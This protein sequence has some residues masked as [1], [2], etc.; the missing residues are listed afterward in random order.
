MNEENITPEAVPAEAEGENGAVGNEAPT[1]A[2]VLSET[3]GKDFKDDETAL[4]SVK[5][6]FSYVGKQRDQVKTEVK[7]E[8][9]IDEVVANVAKQNKELSSELFY[10]KNKEFDSPEVRDMIGSMGNDPK[11]VVQSDAFKKIFDKVKGFEKAQEGANVLKSN[12]N[13]RLDTTS[14]AT[15]TAMKSGSD[16][17]WGKVLQNLI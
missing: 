7:E 17:D 4:K 14:E 3:L 16:K 12:S 5:D 2:S 13:T 9:K 11:E 15:K 8:L 10:M 1:I 6:T